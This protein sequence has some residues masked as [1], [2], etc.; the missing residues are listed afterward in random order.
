M[1]NTATT[2][3]TT[4]LTP[5]QLQHL[6]NALD[7]LLGC[8]EGGVDSEIVR[9]LLKQYGPG[10]K[11]REDARELFHYLKVVGTLPIQYLQQGHDWNEPRAP[12]RD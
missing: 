3:Q 2:R 11:D 9:E 5:E 12:W 8:Y 6:F 4:L 1:T 10:T 7:I